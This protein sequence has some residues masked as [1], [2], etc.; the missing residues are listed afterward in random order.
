MCQRHTLTKRCIE[1]SFIFV[2]FD[3]NADWLKSNSVCRH[4]P[5]LSQTRCNPAVAILG[6]RRGD[7]STCLPSLLLHLCR[8]LSREGRSPERTTPLAH[9][10][11]TLPHCYLMVK[12][13]LYPTN[14]ASRSSGVILLSST[15][16]L[17]N[18]MPLRGS[19]VH[20]YLSSKMTW[21][22]GMRVLPSGRTT[23]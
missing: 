3:L 21:G 5:V 17:W 12:P 10:A 7:K 13:C 11:N 6:C 20:M 23:P 16:G 22:S 15:F 9:K 18:S 2:H 8:G 19:R 1:H 14:H 4:T